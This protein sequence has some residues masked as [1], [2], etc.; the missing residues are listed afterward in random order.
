MKQHNFKNKHTLKYLVSEYETMSQKGEVGFFEKKAFW[1]LIDHYEIKNQLDKAIEVIEHALV[2]YSYSTEFYIR[3]AQ[4]L[5]EKKC[6]YQAIACLEHAQ[7][8]SPSELE[9]FLFK[10]EA[11][12]S[13]GDYE[14]AFELLQALKG[15]LNKE[16]LSEV[17]MLEAHIYENLEDFDE[18]FFALKKAL[19][20]NPKNSVALEKIWLSVELSA[21]YEE[22]VKL[23][24]YLIDEDPYSYIAWYNLG[25]AYTCLEQF[26]DA[27]EAFEYAY[28]INEQFEFAYRDCGEVCLQS[29]QYKRALKCYNEALEFFSPDSDFLLNIGQCHEFMD[30]IA[31]AKTYYT[32]SIQ[33]NSAN[34]LAHY[35]MGECFVKEQQ[36][37]K[38][39]KAYKKALS[40]ENK[41]EEYI[42]ALAEV[43][44][45]V[46]E[47]EKA[48]ILFK[49][50]ADTAPETTKYWI[51]YASF[52]MDI[53]AYKEALIVLEEAEIYA[54]GVELLYCRTACQFLLGHRK[55]ALFLLQTALM[56]NYNM[57]ES[58]FDLVPE[59]EGDPDVIHLI[60]LHRA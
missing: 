48:A 43:Y 9:I 50:A 28:I 52:L 41:R 14:E 31:T 17:L 20:A 55:E 12:C 38:A 13:L 2:Q 3:K 29:K 57:H 7:I 45:Q 1:E 6:A 49:K 51:Q 25:H 44:Y 36:W 42:A 32:K 16:E 39:M 46:E 23:H 26:E 60:G 58:L 35:R 34:D 10:A 53:G 5:I 21:K 22:S 56:E 30:E 33:L 37:D 27:I 19:I 40:I 11:L 24:N 18:M 15:K 8:L 4:L 47:E 54:I 59:V